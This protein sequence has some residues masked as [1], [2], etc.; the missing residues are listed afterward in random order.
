MYDAAHTKT[1][2]WANS[3]DSLIKQKRAQQN[4][5]YN[6]HTLHAVTIWIG[7]LNF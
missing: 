4:R 1:G 5:N 2:A 3:S 6:A 7:F